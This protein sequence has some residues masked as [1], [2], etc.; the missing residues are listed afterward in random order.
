MIG[1]LSPLA[2]LNRS[3]ASSVARSPSRAV[4]GSPGIARISRNTTATMPISTGMARKIR[5]V[6]YVINAVP[7][8]DPG[9]GAQRLPPEIS[10]RMCEIS[11]LR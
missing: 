8:I 6:M 5:R 1:S 7:S 10:Q 11:F 9:G 4:H 2:S 3:H